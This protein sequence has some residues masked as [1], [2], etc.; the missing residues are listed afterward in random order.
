MFALSGLIVSLPANS[1]DKKEIYHQGWI[2]LN[3]NGRM[4]IYEN[5]KAPIDQRVNDLLAQMNVDEKT[6]QTATLYGVGRGRS[7]TDAPL[8]DELPTPEW[9]NKLWKD[10][11]ANIDE[12]LNGWGPN[13]QSVY[14]TDIAKH[15]WAMNEVQRFFIEQTRLGIPVDFT[16]E[17]LRGVAFSTA[18]GFPSELGQGH[19]WDPELIGEIGSIT[20][21]E[22]RALG[23]TNVYAPTLD[24]SR[25]QRWGRIEDTYGEE[26][27][28][29]SR[30]GVEMA[31]AMQKDYRIAATAKH[32]A[33]YSVGKGAREG[34]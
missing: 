24:V 4:D 23:Y 19:T 14:A 28:L 1:Q 5:P 12:H 26:P 10:G 27:F 7:N 22:A 6:C 8:K 15:V 31:K 16:N 2:D 9:K 11:I 30:L 17:G 32:F 3:K 13:G 20:A 34:Q 33:I 29:V 25:D 18:T 21:Q